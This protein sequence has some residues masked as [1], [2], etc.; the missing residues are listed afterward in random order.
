MSM[1]V[2]ITTPQA[3]A[4]RQ[5]MSE[6]KLGHLIPF[7]VERI[8]GEHCWYFYYDLPEGELEL[9]VAWD[10]KVQKWEMAVTAFG[11]GDQR[12]T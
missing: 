12:P 6:R 9:E 11:R 7:D 3:A 4:A 2:D 8:E 5:F 10:S 1:A